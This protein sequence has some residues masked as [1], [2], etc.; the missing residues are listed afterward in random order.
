MDLAYSDEQKLLA[1]SA[2]GLLATRAQRKDASGLWQEMAG[3]GWLALPAPEEHGGLGQGAVDVGILA[4]AFGRHLVAT[5]Y[6][7]CIVLCGG[8]V[9]SAGS[10]EQK[11]A[12]LPSLSVGGATLALAHAEQGARHDL[13]HVG[14]GATRDDGGWR[15]SG[16]KIAALGAGEADRLIVSAR[17]R[18]S[19]DDA[20]GIG[21]FLVEPG[22]AGVVLETYRTVDGASAARLTLNDVKLPA[23]ALLGADENALAQ[24]ERGFDHAVAAWCAEV[25]GLMD[26]AAA[27]TIEYVKI[28][29]QFGK[30]LAANQALRHRI[31]DMAVQCEE[32]R[33]MALRA[34]LYAADDDAAQRA[35]A[36]AGAWAKI[37]R[38][39]RFVAEQAIQLH[40]GMGV[41]DELQ[42]GAYLKRIV[43]LDAIIGSPEHHLRQHAALSARLSRAD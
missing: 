41:T 22:Q 20:N 12:I 2:H 24:I 13:R 23:D 28:R 42:I 7:P 26:A 11:R 34:A 33:A 30:P 27:A 21:L 16:R 5:P 38:G 18:G 8:I 17:I 32:A 15:L 1:E 39:G 14:A 37:S 31:A 6:I 19:L 40:G 9:A 29:V 35:R 3:L 4:E 25:V 10:N 43:A 36:I